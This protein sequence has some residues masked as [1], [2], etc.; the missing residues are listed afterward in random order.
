MGSEVMLFILSLVLLTAATVIYLYKDH[1]NYK[2]I[3]NRCGQIERGL[4]ETETRA[5]S[6]MSV[7]MK[8]KAD[9]DMVQEHCAKIR[10]QQQLLHKRQSYLKAKM[11]PNKIEL[12]IA[13]G[14]AKP[15]DKIEV[16]LTKGNVGPLMQ[17]INKQ[18]DGLSQ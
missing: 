16:E 8:Y 6:A 7:A 3:T 11:I 5:S 1:N 18:L 12:T 13:K 17:K 10:E 9:I 15:L 4:K 2:A 14:N